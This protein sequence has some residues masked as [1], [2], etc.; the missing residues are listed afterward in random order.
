MT[1]SFFSKTVVA[2]IAI[3]LFLAGCDD[4][5]QTGEDLKVALKSI[6]VTPATNPVPLA[7]GDTWQLTAKPEPA[8]AADVN[9]KWTSSATATVTVSDAG[10]VTAV[11]VGSATIIASSGNIQ[12]APITVTVSLK[13]LTSFIVEPASIDNL[14]VGSEEQLVIT[15]TPADAGGS[16]EFESNDDEVATVS[17]EGLVTA[18]G[19]GP[20]TITITPSNSSVAPK[21]VSVTVVLPALESV[22]VEPASIDNLVV[23]SE[24]QLVITKTPADAG[25]SF[26]FKSN[27]DE[28][29]RVSNAG[30]VTA[31]G[32]GPA[33]I[34]ITPSNSNVAA[35][36]VS[37][38]VT[39]PPYAAALDEVHSY[40]GIG[41]AHFEITVSGNTIDKVRIY[42]DNRQGSQEV[43][44]GGQAGV[45]KETVELAAG[46][47]DFTLVPVNSDGEE[48]TAVATASATVY[49]NTALAAAYPSARSV[50]EAV[51]S[52]ETG[53][54]IDIHWAAPLENEVK[55]EVIY[56]NAQG[57]A[58]EV[59]LPAENLTQISVQD[60]TL[61]FQFET[62]I[63]PEPAARDTFITATSTHSNYGNVWDDCEST[64]GW[65][66]TPDITLDADDPR[67]GLY[68]VKKQ[69]T[70]SEVV[71]YLRQGRPAFD[72]GVS[73]TDGYLALSLYVDD[74][75]V[76][77]DTPDGELEITSFGGP[78][79][80][81][82]GWTISTLNLVDGW[83]DLELKLSGAKV[84][85]GEDINLSQLNFLR[86]WCIT[87][88]KAAVMKIDNL[89][90]Y[91]K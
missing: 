83:N 72:A 68:C 89:R 75:T 84:Q 56:T 76:F 12:S 47:H 26:E 37:V 42:W 14:V 31:V 54:G 36:T 39:S 87:T 86:L 10:L 53:I 28:V 8:D 3:A 32:A 60:Q 82:L 49:D 1:K 19:S 48:S 57:E 34:T 81:E 64:D 9:I 44:I 11:E 21:T 67:E 69:V 58:K 4:K 63:L 52:Y 66:N 51:Y 38:T 61:G 80:Q 74:A 20:A 6:T 77:G 33:T 55:T 73:K 70:A 23:G 30:L 35:K 43:T 5:E 24:E 88:S 78:D 18:V 15:K 41:R 90:F 16:F 17:D 85:G 2:G 62:Y 46:N 22:T 45:Y 79:N 59:V 40:A 65:A 13:A 27:D 25:G 29:A 71:I 50:T 7:K 91:E